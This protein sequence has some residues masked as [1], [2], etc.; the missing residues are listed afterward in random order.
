MAPCPLYITSVVP[1]FVKSPKYPPPYFNYNRMESYQTLLVCL[2]NRS[3]YNRM[4]S[5]QNA[6]CLFNKQKFL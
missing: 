2:I 1:Y 4:E 3:N 6:T 5:Y